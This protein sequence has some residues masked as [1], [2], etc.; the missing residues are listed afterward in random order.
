MQ[1]NLPSVEVHTGRTKRV[2]ITFRK[3]EPF[4]AVPF[5]IGAGLKLFSQSCIL[6][7][8]IANHFFQFKNRV[9]DLAEFVF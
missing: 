9:K 8:E 5:Q 7:L 2:G 3:V 1:S 4:F 6:L